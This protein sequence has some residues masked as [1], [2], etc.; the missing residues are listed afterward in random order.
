MIGL[1]Y[2]LIIWLG[3]GLLTGIK[4]IF[5]D[6]DYDEEF[7][8]LMDKETSVG[9]ERNLANLFFKNKLNVLAFFMLIGLLPLIIRITKLFKRG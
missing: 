2:F 5:V 3:V 1:A 8:E 4:F 6:Q 7:K 9:M